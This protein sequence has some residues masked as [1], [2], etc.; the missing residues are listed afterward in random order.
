MP[1]IK[2]QWSLTL[3]VDG[4]PQPP[5]SS[6]TQFAVDAYDVVKLT[7]PAKAAADGT[8]SADVQPS[9]TAGKVVALVITADKYDAG[10]SYAVGT[11][12]TATVLALDGPHVFFGRGM[13]DAIASPFPTALTFTNKTA[14]PVN[15][16]LLVG[17]LT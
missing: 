12:G 6:P 9:T 4:T 15:V 14:A 16:R 3:S 13:I 8:A 10:V 17:R 5:V 11:G 7:V 2:V 1:A